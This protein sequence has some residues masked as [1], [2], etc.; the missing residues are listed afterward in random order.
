MAKHELTAAPDTIHWGFYDATLEPVMKISSGDTFVVDTE[1]GGMAD[2]LELLGRRAPKALR[3]I[4][5]KK[6]RGQELHILT[7]PVEVEDADPGDTLEVRIRDIR[8][9]NDWG[10]TAIR[11]LWG[12]LPEDFPHN[13]TVLVELDRDQGTGELFPGVKVPLRPFFGNLG[14]APPASMG[15]ISSVYPGEWGGNLDNKEL[16]PGATIYFPIHVPGAL[17]SVG[18]GHGCQ[19]DG[20]A[21]LS[22]LETGMSGTFEIVVRKDLKIT[23]PRAETDT[24][25]IL[26]GFDP[27]LDNAIKMALRQTIAFLGETKGMSAEDAYMLCSLGVDLRVTQIV[28]LVKGAHAMVPKSLLG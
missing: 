22:A 26:M 14:V 4:F 13:R 1:S 28:N 17:F 23:L 2:V 6:H 27:I 15:R 5:E 3:E 10:Y 21:C 24:H 19:G 25:Y 8:P 11:A 12:G 20:E 16:V 18:D 9:R 7:G